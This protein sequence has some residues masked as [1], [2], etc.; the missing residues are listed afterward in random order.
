[1]ENPKPYAPVAW[2]A[3][4]W[5]AQTTRITFQIPSNHVHIHQKNEAKIQQ[6]NDQDINHTIWRGRLC[7]SKVRFFDAFFALFSILLGNYDAFGGM[8]SNIL[9]NVILMFFRHHF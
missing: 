7:P 1:M 6:Q 2:G 9:A 4:I 5:E 3:I 8:Q